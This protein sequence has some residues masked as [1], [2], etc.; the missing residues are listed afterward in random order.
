MAPRKGETAVQ[1][2][3]RLKLAADKLRARA[4]Q[5]RVFGILKQNHQKVLELE[6]EFIEYGLLSVTDDTLLH[7]PKPAKA[8]LALK[9]GDA[10]DDEG[11]GGSVS[12][13]SYL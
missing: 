3:Q 5:T 1:K 6:K 11:G 4:A 10:H 9:D 12:L 13:C 2:A 7:K 8:A